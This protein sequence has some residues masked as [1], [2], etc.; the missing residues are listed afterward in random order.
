M[1]L[2][3]CSFFYQESPVAIANNRV[4]FFK[5][6]LTATKVLHVGC[7]DYPIQNIENNLHIALSKFITDL[8]GFDID[9]AGLE[10]LKSLV[11]GKYFSSVDQ[12]IEHY[13]YVLVPEVIEHVPNIEQ[14]LSDLNRI[15]TTYFIITAPNAYFLEHED[16]CYLQK[17]GF[18]FEEVHPD[19][20][21]WF[22]PYT[23]SN[24][25]KKY[26]P[27]KIENIYLLQA[28]SMVCII[29]KK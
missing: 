7:T 3:Q 22:S 27:W 21:C 8:S 23:L 13:D 5:K 12:I 15:D 26:T 28:H 11:P 20:N 2:S 1:S 29:C 10:A 17:N 19:H 6:I 9:K 25:I 18:Y 16:H 14:F 24:C 4:E